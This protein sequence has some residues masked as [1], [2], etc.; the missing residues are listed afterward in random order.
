M[1]E[2]Y[3]NLQ[4]Q[5][6]FEF[7][8]EANNLQDVLD[9]ISQIEGVKVYRE[10]RPVVETVITKEGIAGCIEGFS[11]EGRCALA[12]EEKILDI[13]F[14]QELVNYETRVHFRDLATRRIVIK[15][16]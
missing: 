12:A 6:E 9:A 10:Q 13:L 4:K 15:R 16:G 14:K 11:V 1:Q 2:R 8:C 3:P 7:T 5:F